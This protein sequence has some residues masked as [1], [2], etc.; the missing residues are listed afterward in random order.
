MVNFS[1]LPIIKNFRELQAKRK[2]E[3]EEAKLKELWSNVYNGIMSVVYERGERKERSRG[4][5][6]ADLYNE[7]FRRLEQELNSM[8]REELEEMHSRIGEVAKKWLDEYLELCK[9]API[10]R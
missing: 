8:N 1:E 6:H 2:K 10:S 4:R 9:T 3:K 7:T 5:P